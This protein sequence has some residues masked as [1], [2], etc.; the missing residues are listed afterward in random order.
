[1]GVCSVQ[2]HPSNE[3]IV[4]S[5]SYDEQVLIWDKRKW[6]EPSGSFEAGGGVW[7]IKFN[8]FNSDQIA[9]ACMYEGFKIFNWSNGQKSKSNSL[10]FSS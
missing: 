9:L 10:S 1:M 7:R 3:N 8:P 6:N 5:G 2:C 4:L